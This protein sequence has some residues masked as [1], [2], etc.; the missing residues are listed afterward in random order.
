[1]ADS[2]TPTGYQGKFA[3]PGTRFPGSAGNGTITIVAAADGQWLQVHYEAGDNPL[4]LV[5]G[6][7]KGETLRLDP[8]STVAFQ[9]TKPAAGVEIHFEGKAVGTWAW[10]SED[11]GK[12]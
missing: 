10:L 7:D 11:G 2:N 5:V 12:K 6:G 8:A 3:S 4:T 1:M 9:V